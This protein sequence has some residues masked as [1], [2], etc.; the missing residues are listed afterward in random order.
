MCFVKTQKDGYSKFLSLPAL[1][2][3]WMQERVNAINDF[4]PGDKNTILI[5]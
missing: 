2:Y 5:A 4:F 3:H 1:L